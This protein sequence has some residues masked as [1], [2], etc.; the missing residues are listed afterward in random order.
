MNYAPKFPLKRDNINGYDMITDIKQLIKFHLKNLLLTTPGERISDPEYGIGARR[1]LFE[2]L[3]PGTASR[4]SDEMR[5]QIESYLSYVN[6][7]QLSVVQEEESNALVI[8]L[9]Y[10]IPSLGIR[11]NEEVKI[12]G[13][14]PSGNDI[15]F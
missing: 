15:P 7:I 9:N 3:T 5:R 10:S 14:A 1:Y 13:F 4:V 11:D 2:P 12:S 8:K 6:I